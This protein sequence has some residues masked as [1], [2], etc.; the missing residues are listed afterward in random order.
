MMQRHRIVLDTSI[1]AELKAARAR[2]LDDPKVLKRKVRNVCH[3]DSPHA[4]A[5]YTLAA[6]HRF[7]WT[8]QD[9]K[10]V[11]DK[12]EGCELTVAQWLKG[13]DNENTD[14]TAT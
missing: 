9:W 7:N 3:T 2:L 11:L 4:E 13:T 5:I 10:T 8:P 6:G 12:L 1:D 14:T